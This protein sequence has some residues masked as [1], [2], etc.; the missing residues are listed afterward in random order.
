[1][2][3]VMRRTMRSSDEASVKLDEGMRAWDHAVT[4]RHRAGWRVSKQATGGSSGRRK[5]DI[6][7]NLQ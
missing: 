4:V 6:W 1:M 3:G 5:A 2:Y 7:S